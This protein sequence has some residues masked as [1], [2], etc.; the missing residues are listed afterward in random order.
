MNLGELKP[1]RGAVHRRKRLGTGTGS[2]HGG[3]CGRG[4][5]GQNSRTGKGKVH[6]YFEGGQLP[7]HRRVP[8]LGFTPFGRVPYQVVNVGDLAAFG[9]GSKITPAELKAR[10]LVRKA[11]GPIKLLAS[12]ELS[13]SVVVHVD[14][15]SEAARRK[16]EAAGGQVAGRG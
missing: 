4:T 10:G 11:D 13:V 14:A 3:T 7:L 12:G 1:A 9:A 16:I 6:I 15:A 8:K 5:K 2:G